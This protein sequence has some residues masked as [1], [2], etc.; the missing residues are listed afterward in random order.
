MTT[1]TPQQF[2]AQSKNYL[3]EMRK[4]KRMSVDVGLTEG[5]EGV[6]EN[7]ATVLQVGATHEFGADIEHK[8]GH[9]VHIPERSYLR[10]PFVEREEKMNARIN[11]EFAAILD[12][13]QT[14]EK[15]LARIGIDAR[16]VVLEAFDTGGFHK[17]EALSEPYATKK[18]KEKKAG[19]LKRTGLLR[20]SIT[21]VVKDGN[22]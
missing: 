22:A 1:L 21:W 20:G 12:G 13:K 3:E 16:N 11:G 6:Y 19:I 10:A 5:S 15:A 4:A 17:W 18:R 8:A 7:G 2:L 14:T 9:I